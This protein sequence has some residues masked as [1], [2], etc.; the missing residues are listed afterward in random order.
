MYALLVETIN[1]KYTRASKMCDQYD[2][3]CPTCGKKEIYNDYYGECMDCL[4]AFANDTIR[5]MNEDRD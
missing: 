5:L 2:N 1:L 4:E 3:I